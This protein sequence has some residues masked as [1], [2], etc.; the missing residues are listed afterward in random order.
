MS[1]CSC[2]SVSFLSLSL[3]LSASMQRRERSTEFRLQV[4]FPDP[5]RTGVTGA[6]PCCPQFSNP[7]QHCLSYLGA[8]PYSCPLQR[9]SDGRVDVLDKT[10]HSFDTAGPRAVPGIDLRDNGAGGAGRFRLL[11]TQSA[12]LLTVSAAVARLI[13]LGCWWLVD[14][15][16]SGSQPLDDCVSNRVELYDQ[17]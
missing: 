3:V 1:L 10:R 6:E 5:D 15:S 13:D 9:C 8:Y 14:Y 2:L 17:I 4:S 12:K 7:F 11:P 16:K